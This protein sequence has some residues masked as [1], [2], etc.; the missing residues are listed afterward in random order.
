M[1]IFFNRE[2]DVLN[3]SVLRN[4]WEGGGEESGKIWVIFK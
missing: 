4:I 3:I 2:N 1:L